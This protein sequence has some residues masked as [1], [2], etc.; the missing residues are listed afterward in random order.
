V[1]GFLAG[2]AGTGRTILKQFAQKCLITVEL[3]GGAPKAIPAIRRAP[4]TEKAAEDDKRRQSALW[5]NDVA[6]SVDLYNTWFM[7]FAPRTYR[8]KRVE[9]TKHVETGLL[10]TGD[11]EQ[12]T[13]AVL[14][15]K[16]AILPMLRMATCPPLARDRLVGLAYADKNV[17][18]CHGR[19]RLPNPHRCRSWATERTPPR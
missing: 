1:T 16:P 18:L 9:V 5:K 8:E 6:A 14:H 12:V 3:N 15:A 10:K 2:F 7:K 19:R 17:V 11:L 13:P 4:E